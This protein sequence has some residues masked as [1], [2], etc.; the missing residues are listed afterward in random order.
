MIYSMMCMWLCG[1]DQETWL[2]YGELG[3]KY[4]GKMEALG[5]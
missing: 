1:E 3:C 4:E 5:Q 2:G